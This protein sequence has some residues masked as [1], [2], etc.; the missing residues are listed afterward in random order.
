MCLPEPTEAGGGRV[1][2][3]HGVMGSRIPNPA[4][5][6]NMFAGIRL[7]MS[8]YPK[9]VEEQRY[10]SSPNN[11]I[12]FMAMMWWYNSALVKPFLF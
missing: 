12:A 7:G 6:S 2:G 3:G 1:G 9:A 11:Y 4:G 10:P 8:N 5:G